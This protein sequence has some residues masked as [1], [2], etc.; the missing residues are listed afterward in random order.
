MKYAIFHDFF[1]FSEFLKKNSFGIS[2]FLFWVGSG[3]TQSAVPWDTRVGTPTGS[4]GHSWTWA[5][6]ADGPMGP[7]DLWAD[8]PL[9]PQGLKV[10][11]PMGPGPRGPGGK[12]I[13]IMI[14]N[15]VDYK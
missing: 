14:S 7:R 10:P 5:P 9:G 8:G 4:Q 12:I 6:W 13:K 3:G 1:D 2:F 15:P 11:G